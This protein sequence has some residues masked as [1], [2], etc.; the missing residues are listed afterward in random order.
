MNQKGEN[1][2]PE[3]KE[4][5]EYFINPNKKIIPYRVS[6]PP[7]IDNDHFFIRKTKYS[8]RIGII[9]KKIG[10]IGYR[11]PPKSKNTTFLIGMKK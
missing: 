8:I 3:E 10:M 5:L 11:I 4:M 2:S 7:L 9:T 1:L 6:I